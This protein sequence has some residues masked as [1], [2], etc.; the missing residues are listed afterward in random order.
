MWSQYR[1]PTS[2]SRTAG[3]T[4]GWTT[5]RTVVAIGLGEIA[6][7]R[8]R[9]INKKPSCRYDSRPYCLTTVSQY[10]VCRTCSAFPIRSRIPNLKSLA[11]SFGDKFDRMPKIVGV[12]WPR[13]RPLSGKL[14][15]RLLGIRHIKLHT[16]FEVSTSSSFRDIALWAYSGHEFDLS[17]NVIGH[18]TIR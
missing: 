1:R 7:Q 5:C 2:T 8:W 9:L 12:T 3:Q 11:R 16:K 14:F 17:S 15:V 4:D 6:Y 13:P 18:V 10:S